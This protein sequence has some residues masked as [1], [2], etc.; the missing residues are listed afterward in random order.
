MLKI[1]L[2][3]GT[4]FVKCVSDYGSVRF[5]SVYVQKVHG[6]WTNKTTEAVGND[7]LN[8]INTLGAS[9]IRPISRGQPDSKYQ[10]QVEMLIQES[11]NQVYLCSKTPVDT[12]QKIRMVVGLPYHA[13]NS[14][15]SITRLIKKILSVKECTAVAQA[16]GTLVDLGIDTGM[17]V[18]VGQ[19]TTEMIVID[20]LDVID[21]ESSSWAS[22][23]VTKKIGRF[24]HLNT[25]TLHQNTDMCKK[26]SKILAANL[27]QEICEMAENHN[28]R[29]PVA[30]S[31]GGLLI[32]GM[33][34]EL[35]AGLKKFKVLVPDDPVM[36]NARGL[37]K[38]A[39]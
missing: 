25:D 1:G 15:E 17:V 16:S 38:I 18:S 31:G 27:T 30:L 22:D 37:Y 33:S 21:G 29:Y 36:S 23:F 19:G 2:D 4:G 12:K 6:I 24:A 26:Y 34:E 39:G 13:F 3:L 20:D 8:M 10:K 14:K 32:P 11:I 9:V 35:L 28:N 7:A 5:P